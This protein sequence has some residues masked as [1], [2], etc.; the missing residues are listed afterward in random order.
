[1]RD[2]LNELTRVDDAESVIERLEALWSEE[3]YRSQGS[4][5]REE[6]NERT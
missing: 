4:W 1:M 5:T 6:L 3:S 2:C